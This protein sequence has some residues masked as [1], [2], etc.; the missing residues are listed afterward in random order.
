[1]SAPLYVALLHY[2][3]YKKDGE[4]ITTCITPMDLHDIARTCITFGVRQYYVVNHMPTMQYLARR[5]ADFWL[6]DY[7]FNYNRTRTDAFSIMRLKSYLEECID[8]I[9]AEHG[10]K[11]ILTA[12]T[13]KRFDNSIGYSLLAQKLQQE[14]TPY[15][16][17]FGT[18]YGLIREFLRRCDMVLEPINGVGDYNH[19]SV[20]SAAAIVLDRLFNEANTG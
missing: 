17:L 16:L 2:P 19:L 7:G 18:G 14:N 3:V 10:V 13:A 15:L 8:E 11:P 5:V 12:T 6:S 1:M 9:Y 4:V 20:R